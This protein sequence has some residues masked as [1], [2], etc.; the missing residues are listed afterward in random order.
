MDLSIGVDGLRLAEA[1]GQARADA[2]IIA[3]ML[4][5]A[6]E[7]DERLAGVDRSVPDVV[8]HPRP[9]VKPHPG[10]Q[11][12]EAAGRWEVWS[13]AEGGWVSLDDGTVQEP[14]T[15]STEPHEHA[16]LRPPPIEL[17]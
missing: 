1:A 10:A 6:H 3:D 4:N 15:R 5:R 14:G 12:D 9:A 13:E 7:H 16:L 2:S 11:W 8:R 17:R